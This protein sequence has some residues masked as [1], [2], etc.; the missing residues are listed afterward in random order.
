MLES[1]RQYRRLGGR[2]RQNGERAS[3]VQ[4]RPGCIERFPRTVAGIAPVANFWSVEVQV[5]LKKC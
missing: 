1:V 5:K 2:S 4:C 3:I